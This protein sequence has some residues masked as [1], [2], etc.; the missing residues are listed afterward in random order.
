MKKIKLYMLSFL[1][2]LILLLASCGSKN[3]GSNESKKTKTISIGYQSGMP[4]FTIAKERGSLAKA[5]AKKG[6]K[7]SWHYFDSTTDMINSAGNTNGVD[8]GGGG[9]TAFVFGQASDKSIVKV[10]AQTSAG[11]GSAIIVRK[12][13]GINSVKDLKG[14]KVAVT[15]GAVQQYELVEALKN[16]GLSYKDI[17]VEYMAPSD[18]LAAYKKGGQFDALII[19]DPLL[20]QA[21]KSVSTKVIAY[22][23]TIFG[24]NAD[25][26]SVAYYFASTNFLKHNKAA[27]KLII[28]EIRKSAEWY[29]NNPKAAAKLLAKAYNT[30][31]NYVYTAAK[32]SGSNKIIPVNKDLLS[33][34][35]AQADVFYNLKLVPKKINV[36]DSK[37]YWNYTK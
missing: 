14:K 25:R 12:N 31:F 9:S 29:K 11:R 24:K 6:Y 2:I 28:S 37:Y 34:L 3:S 21:Q 13:S 16:A 23:G 1:S 27:V 35:Q 7:V 33:D 22:R 8:F 5:L 4:V 15:K 36:Y 20:A 26:K 19:W 30:N 18:A 10:A 17:K 32:R